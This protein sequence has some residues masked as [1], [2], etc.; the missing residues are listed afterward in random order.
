MAS[1]TATYLGFV[2][3][4]GNS[5]LAIYRSRGDAAA[6]LFVLASYLSLVLLFCCLRRFEAS[7]PGSAAR[8][9]ARVGVWL[10][11]TV[12]TAL[13]SWRV[14]AVMPCP[15]AAGVWFMGGCT[16]AGGYYALFLLP[17]G[18]GDY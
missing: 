6:V 7:A 14:A 13:F 11:T 12:L 5:V 9:R 16:V 2:L 3:L 4:T 18:E 10:A 17:R 1:K 15:V 8:D